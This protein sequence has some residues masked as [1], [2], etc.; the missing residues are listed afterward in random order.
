VG[1]IDSCCFDEAALA[2][3]S[4]PLKRW[5]MNQ[6]RALCKDLPKPG[7][8]LCLE[9]PIET[10]IRRD[11]RRVK[12]GGPDAA[13]LLRRWELESRFEFSATPAMR[14]DTSRPLEEVV[15]TVVGAVWSAL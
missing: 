11:A 15:R 10:T 3:C 7:L 2:R 1:A 13:A 8:V 5:L 6:E 14:I 9:A 4:S 12:H